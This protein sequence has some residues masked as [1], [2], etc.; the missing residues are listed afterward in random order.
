MSRRAQTL[1][2]CLRLL[3]CGPETTRDLALHVG[4]TRA[5]VAVA[6]HG[7]P[8]VERDGDVWS[9]SK[10]RAIADSRKREEQ[11]KPQSWAAP[12][13]WLA[14]NPGF[15]TYTAIAEGSGA[16]YSGVT[17]ALGRHRELFNWSQDARGRV[18]VMWKGQ[19]VRA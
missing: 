15:H 3:A 14:D 6:L 19:A 11:A 18:L 4:T 8:G 9:L 12:V 2:G 17:V 16:S 7:E 5:L 10:A 1:A 13:R